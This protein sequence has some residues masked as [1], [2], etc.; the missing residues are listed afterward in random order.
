MLLIKFSSSTLDDKAAIDIKLAECTGTM[1]N[2]T[3]F[4]QQVELNVG[5]GRDER[6]SDGKLQ[7]K[8]PKD[9]TKWTKNYLFPSPRHN[10]PSQHAPVP[11][12]LTLILS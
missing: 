2:E 12:Y 10:P 6:K 4:S 11:T 3:H 9:V 8:V 1:S 7:K 5:Q